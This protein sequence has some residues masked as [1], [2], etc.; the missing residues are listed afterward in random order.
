MT[1][2]LAQDELR[3]DPK[4]SLGALLQACLAAPV[5]NSMIGTMTSAMYP[6]CPASVKLQSVS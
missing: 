6:L 5:V 2:N 3:L 1:D 4:A